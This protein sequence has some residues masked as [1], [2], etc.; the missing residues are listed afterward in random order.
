MQ[1]LVV[2]YMQLVLSASMVNCLVTQYVVKSAKKCLEVGRSM[3]KQV[4][5]PVSSRVISNTD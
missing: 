3:M 2:Q 1:R 4:R 5:E